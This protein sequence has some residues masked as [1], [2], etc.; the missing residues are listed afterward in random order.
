MNFCPS[1]EKILGT[2]LSRNSR[3]ISSFG[4]DSCQ[5]S[6][7]LPFHYWQLRFLVPAGI[8][9]KYPAGDPAK[10][11]CKFLA[12]SIRAS[13]LAHWGR[14]IWGLH[15]SATADNRYIEQCLSLRGTP[16]FWLRSHKTCGKPFVGV[17]A[18]SIQ[19]SL[20]YI[21]VF[22]RLPCMSAALTFIP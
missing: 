20:R 7:P 18:L 3:L 16:A 1:M 21:A 11:F 12:P 4:N 9:L 15:S 13:M 2:N 6:A 14:C 19:V 10:H 8:L 17:F 5:L 22:V